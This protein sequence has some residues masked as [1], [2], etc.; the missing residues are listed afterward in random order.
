MKQNSAPIKSF[1]PKSFQTLIKFIKITQ[2]LNRKPS[3]PQFVGNWTSNR[4]K[5]G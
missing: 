3:K 2:N 4:M 5:E 1:T